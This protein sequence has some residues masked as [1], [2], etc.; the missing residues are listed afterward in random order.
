MTQLLNNIV[1]VAYADASVLKS[2]VIVPGCV[3]A[4]VD[5]DAFTALPVVGL[6]SAETSAKI[7]NKSIIYTATVSALLS[8]HFNPDNR[9]LVFLLKTVDRSMLL[10][11][12]DDRHHPVITVSDAMPSKMTEVSGCNVVIEYTDLYGILP[13]ILKL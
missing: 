9:R 10:I 3:A 11:G 1:S 6:A 4:N 12:S 5:P 13:V 7:S 8:K 2:V